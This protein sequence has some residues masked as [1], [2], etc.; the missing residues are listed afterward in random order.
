MS[1]QPGGY[2]ENVQRA[3]REGYEIGL[4]AQIVER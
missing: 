1:A 4:T 3:A 2:Y